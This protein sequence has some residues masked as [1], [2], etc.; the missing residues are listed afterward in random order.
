MEHLEQLVSDFQ[1]LEGLGASWGHLKSIL[2]P[3]WAHLGSLP[4]PS[5][6][7]LRPSQGFLEAFS[8]FLGPFWGHLG[9]LW[10]YLGPHWVHLGSSWTFCGSFGALLGLIWGFSG[11]L[12]EPSWDHVDAILGLRSMM[13][14]P[15]SRRPYHL[16]VRGCYHFFPIHS[17]T[18]T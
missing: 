4:G 18:E 3:S 6:G 5:R 15:F 11:A 10:S 8:G 2:G 9:S 13:L 1:N 14:D 12:S 17:P 16:H 7:P